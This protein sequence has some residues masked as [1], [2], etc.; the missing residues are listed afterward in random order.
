MRIQHPIS[1]NLLNLYFQML[2]QKINQCKCLRVE[3]FV[4]E[5]DLDKGE[6]IF[7]LF[8]DFELALAEP[9]F[10]ESFEVVD[11]EG[12]AVLLVREVEEADY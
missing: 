5:H 12:F 8:S 6:A 7:R 9:A 1:H 2:L 3:G 4:M 11:L 10:H